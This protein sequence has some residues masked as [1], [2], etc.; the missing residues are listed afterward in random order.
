MRTRFISVL[1][2]ISSFFSCRDSGNPEKDASYWIARGDS[3][4][5]KTFDTLRNTLL[6]AIGE[7]GF[8]GAVSFCNTEALKLTN[9]FAGEG[10]AIKRTSDKLRNP[11]NAP[12]NLE[13][14]IL[15]EYLNLKKENK[16]LKPVLKK[17][18]AGN[19]HYFKPIIVQTMC[20]SCHGDKSGPLLPDTWQAIEQ[21]YP[22]DKAFDY[23]E[24]DLRG[25]WHV[26]F[27]E[28][29]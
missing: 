23:K 13:K 28:R 6:R 17:D 15:S 7:H 2:L 27:S 12:D 14:E 10:V 8:A 1:A 3:L 26:T 11:M 29:K 5:A 18:A 19:H 9:T 21:K 22:N 16:E 20:L 4:V 24:G 25:I